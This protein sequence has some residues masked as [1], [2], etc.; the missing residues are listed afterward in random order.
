MKYIIPTVFITILW[1][2]LIGG[3]LNTI[4]KSKIENRDVVKKCVIDT[5]YVTESPSTIEYGKRY[6]YKTSCDEVLLTKRNNIYEI[7]DT[8]TFIYKKR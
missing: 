1:I 7:G 8:L 3:I 4:P 2:Y 5:M 6:N